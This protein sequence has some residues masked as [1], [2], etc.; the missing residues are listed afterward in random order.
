MIV[1]S[2]FDKSTNMVKPWLDAG[3]LCYCVDIQH[4]KTARD[5]NLIR[6][7]ADMLNWLPPRDPVAFAA[8]FPPCTDVA[9]SGA[10]WFRDKGI[11]AFYFLLVQNSE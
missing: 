11:E 7:K 9:V 6:V 10:R 8:F 1:L 4:E 5:G 2:C 3:Y